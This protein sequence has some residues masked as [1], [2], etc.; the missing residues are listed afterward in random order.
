MKD[1]FMRRKKR[2]RLMEG[3]GLGACTD[4]AGIALRD[5]AVPPKIPPTLFRWKTRC[6]R[7]NHLQSRSF[8]SQS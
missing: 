5:R 6:N 8:V 4:A 7:I 3:G 2:L 1:S